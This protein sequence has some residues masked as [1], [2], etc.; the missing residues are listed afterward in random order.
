MDA[1][2][3]TELRE[4]YLNTVRAAET[5]RDAAEQMKS[6]RDFYHALAS[7]YERAAHEMGAMLDAAERAIETNEKAA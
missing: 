5:Y 4:R 3:I 7:T 1:V 2:A 6:L